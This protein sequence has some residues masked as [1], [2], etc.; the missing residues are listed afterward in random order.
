MFQLASF[1]NVET[2]FSVCA[3]SRARPRVFYLFSGSPVGFFQVKL[4]IALKIHP[5]ISK[6][7]FDDRAHAVFEDTPVVR[8]FT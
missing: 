5:R 8:E 1:K 2:F 4:L 3:R 6:S 7:C